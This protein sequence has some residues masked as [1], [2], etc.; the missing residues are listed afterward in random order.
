[1][2]NK[3]IMKTEICEKE[4]HQFRILKYWYK[5]EEINITSTATYSLPKNEEWYVLMVCLKCGK[6]I[7]KKAEKEEYGALEM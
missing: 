7:I 5:K 1:M 6:T 2:K 3:K 4:G